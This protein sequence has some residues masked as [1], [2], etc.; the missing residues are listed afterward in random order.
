MIRALLQRMRPKRRLLI[1][2]A[3]VADADA[4][5]A[6]ARVGHSYPNQVVALKDVNLNIRSGEFVCLLGPSGCGKSTL[7][8]ALAGHLTPS[9]GS[10]SIDGQARARPR[11]RAPAHVPGRRRSSRG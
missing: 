9:G 6:M 8:Y 7:L 3:R 4:K 11:P 1:P 2:A 10:V 5:L